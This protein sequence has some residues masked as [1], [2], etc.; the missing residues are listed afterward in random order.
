MTNN[1]GSEISLENEIENEINKMSLEE[2]QYLELNPNHYIY[3][4]LN[5]QIE[6]IK[7]LEIDV[8][9][10]RDEFASMKYQKLDVDDKLKEQYENNYKYVNNL[11]EE[12]RKLDYKLTKNEFINLFNIELKK[13]NN[14]DGLFNQMK[15]GKIN[16]DE[17]KKQFSKLG[18]GKNYYFYKLISDKINS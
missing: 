4:K 17:F 15:D 10:M 8:N 9:S 1:Q 12:R 3:S 14:P 7:K 13:F 18:N 2:L 11:L 5:S 6:N 16:Y